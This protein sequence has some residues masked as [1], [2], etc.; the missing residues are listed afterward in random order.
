MQTP[1]EMSPADLYDAYVTGG[2]S[3]RA[4]VSRLT[5]FGVT[6]AVAAAYANSASAETAAAGGA[7]GSAPGLYGSVPPDLY[8]PTLYSPTLYPPSL[9]GPS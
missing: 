7:V 4:F 5:A 1:D 6:A 8:P 9:Y 3:R 2:I